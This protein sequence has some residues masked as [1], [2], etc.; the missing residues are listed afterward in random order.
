MNHVVI[1]GNRSRR[2]HPQVGQT[3]KSDTLNSISTAAFAH[4]L[5][6]LAL[7]IYHSYEAQDFIQ[8]SPLNVLSSKS[9]VFRG[10]Y[11]LQDCFAHV[12]PLWV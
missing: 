11:F 2:V 3:L 1:F 10:L 8:R 4:T 5:P 6:S 9:D 7:L 12:L